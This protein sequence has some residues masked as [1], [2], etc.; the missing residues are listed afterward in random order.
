MFR[1]NSLYAMISRI[2]ELYESLRNVFHLRANL[3]YADRMI[4]NEEY[5]K[6]SQLVVIIATINNN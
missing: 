3:K 1:W 5:I 4:S 2:V 6:L